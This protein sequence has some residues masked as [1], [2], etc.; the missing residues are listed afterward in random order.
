M[1][2]TASGAAGAPEAGATSEAADTS[3]AG[4]APKAGGRPRLGLLEWLILALAVFGA[5]SAIWSLDWVASV[6]AAGIVLG[7]CFYL[8]LGRHI[9]RISL[10]ARASALFLL[11]AV[12][13]LVS[14]LSV[15]GY[16]FH[17]WR[18]SLEKDGVLTATGTFGYANAL[19]GLLLL[20]LAATAALYLESRHPSL[21]DMRPDSAAHTEAKLQ[22]GR[23]QA[24]GRLLL[25]AAAAP[26]VATLVLTRS[27]AAAAV[28]VVLVLLFLIARAFGAAGGTRR[29]R[30]LGIALTL[31][32]VCGLV[33]GGVLLWKEVAPQMAASGLP[34]SGSDPEDIVPMTSNSFRIKTWMAALEAARARPVLGYGLDTFY[35]AYSPFKL[36]AHT[37]YAHNVVIQHLVEVGG[38]GTALLV[39]FLL[40]ATLRPVKTLL[41]SLRNSQIPLLLGVQA[42]VLHNLVDLT[43]YFPALLFVF[44]LVLG[45]TVSYPR[46]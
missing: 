6:R 11:A 42:F 44:A 33:A 28:I 2:G 9:G 21:R 26:Q 25:A 3:E 35:E 4:A 38:I 32:L 41:G 7:G 34:P 12:G 1:T 37:A 20:T 23:R 16:A 43:W 18:F 36:G 19:A 40:V 10:T 15:V 22:T 46:Q 17:W 39:A 8:Y 27:R 5:L 29:R 13:V 31:L 24:F 45:L 30:W 14:L